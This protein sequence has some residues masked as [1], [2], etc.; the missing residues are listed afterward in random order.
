[1]NE[2]GKNKKPD[3]PPTHNK[4]ENRRFT[5]PADQHRLIMRYSE[6]EDE[7]SRALANELVDY[8]PDGRKIAA[9]QVIEKDVFGMPGVMHVRIDCNYAVTEIKD[10]I[11]SLYH[12][13][14]EQDV[15]YIAGVFVEKFRK[16]RTT[17][18]AIEATIKHVKKEGYKF[19]IEGF[20]IHTMPKIFDHLSIDRATEIIDPKQEHVFKVRKRLQ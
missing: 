6:P 2:D 3:R 18:K 9:A 11:A 8:Y 17:K 12:A 1:M 5:L 16:Y 14:P 7:K 20:T 10:V 15:P 4:R 13:A 19:T